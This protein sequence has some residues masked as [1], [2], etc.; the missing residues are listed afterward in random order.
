MLLV[1]DVT[2]ILATLIQQFP[3]LT[4]IQL[5]TKP[6]PGQAFY[7]PDQR[8]IEVDPTYDP[9]TNPRIIYH[10]LGHALHDAAAR[11]RDAI[12]HHGTGSYDV[13]TDFWRARGYPN[14]WQDA[15]AKAQALLPIASYAQAY[16]Y[17]PKEAFAECFAAVMTAQALE[18]QSPADL[19]VTTYGIPLDAAKMLA[20]FHACELAWIP[21]NLPPVQK[22]PVNIPDP[23]GFLLSHPIT[24]LFGVPEPQSPSGF[25]TGIDLAMNDGVPVPTIHAGQVR[26]AGQADALSGI[27][28]IVVTANADE[29]W[30]A[31]LSGVACAVGD[32]VKFGDVIGYAG[33]SGAATGPHL[34]L[35]WQSPKGT[36]VDPYEEAQML[37]QEA[38]DEIRAI[39]RAEC[40]AIA[41][42]LDSGFNTTMPVELRRIAR[43]HDP[44]V[45]GQ[46]SAVLP[47]DTLYPRLAP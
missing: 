10:E 41:V 44:A 3:I 43:G 46:D 12:Y 33:H 30:H 14:T 11:N 27:A 29:W 45:A 22:G 18:D 24:Q 16:L 4:G 9:T 17:M 7:L 1:P 28:V 42:K 31:H 5:A 26:V 8:T 37:S 36:P 20:F 23:A 47:G 40:A 13:L 6:H 38:Q 32:Q 34:H 15:D 21:P 39:V 25:H 19:H 2:Q 35:E